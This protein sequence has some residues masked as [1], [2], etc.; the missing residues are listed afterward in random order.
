MKATCKKKIE[1]Y[2]FFILVDL[3]F[4]NW[5]Q[6]NSAFHGFEEFLQQL[7]C[8]I[9]AI[10]TFDKNVMLVIFA[11]ANRTCDLIYESVEAIKNGLFD[12]LNK[13]SYIDGIITSILKRIKR[14]LTSIN[15]KNTNP[16]TAYST[17]LAHSL[18]FLNSALKSDFLSKYVLKKPRMLILAG[19]RDTKEQYASIMSSVSAALN[20]SIS[21]DL[22]IIGQAKTPIL[23]CASSLT[24]G[25]FLRL[26]RTRTMLQNLIN[27]FVSDDSSY[28]MLR[29]CSRKLI[30]TICLCHMETVDKGYLCTF[31]NTVM[32]N[33]FAYCINCGTKLRKDSGLSD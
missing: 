26:E 4:S 7:V 16:K 10:F 9:K 14:T 23:K 32:C 13:L 21:T 11:L 18:C 19:S 6:S 28:F 17:A 1:K 24:G 8:F 5:I 31:C 12:S 2:F 3:N 20:V 25:I 22:C 30:K 29:K 15:L 27:Y 33:T